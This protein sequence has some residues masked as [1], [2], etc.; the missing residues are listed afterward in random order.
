M[1]MMMEVKAYE[2]EGP[3]THYLACRKYTNALSMS[4]EPPED[5]M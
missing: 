5:V 3:T 4:I 1:V 2:E